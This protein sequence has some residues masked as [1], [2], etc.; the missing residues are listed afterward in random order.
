MIHS[1]KTFILVGSFI[2]TGWNVESLHDRITDRSIKFAE[3]PAKSSDNGVVANLEMTCHGRERR[4]RIALSAELTPGEIAASLRVDDG[5]VQKQ[6]LHVYSDPHR[7]PIIQAPPFDLIRN[8]RIRIELSPYGSG[9]LFYDFDLTGIRSTA[10]A[11]G[12]P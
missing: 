8:N 12:C 9:P 4:F 7:I 11:I 2:L 3:L 1:L 5:K 10:K 6:I